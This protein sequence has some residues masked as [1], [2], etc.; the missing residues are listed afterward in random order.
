MDRKLLVFLSHHKC[1]T[2]WISSIFHEAVNF[3]GGSC[4]NATN[5]G[6]FDGDLAEFCGSGNIRFLSYVNAEYRY[7]GDVENILGFHVVRDPRDLLVSSYFSSLKTH[8]SRHWPELEPHREQL[9]KVTTEQGLLL[10]M[11]FIA[12]VFEA[13][14][15]WNYGDQRILEIKMED[16]LVNNYTVFSRIAV[17]LGLLDEN[18]GST[19][20][21][22]IQSNNTLRMLYNRFLT[23]TRVLKRMTVYPEK[24]PMLQ[25]LGFIHRNRFE[26]KA[27]GRSRGTEDQDSHY[28]KG[29]AGDWVNHFT[30]SVKDEFKKKYGDLLIRLGYE[31][32]HNW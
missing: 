20:S 1:G 10:E 12:D 30:D 24:V 31:N 9:K 14:T 23:K 29:V 25:F 21:S 7:I 19:S 5:S 3:I 15:S 4:F 13:L 11:N 2:R 27:K 32:D 18:D 22:L 8:S 6:M 17:H 16:L 26:A 28:R